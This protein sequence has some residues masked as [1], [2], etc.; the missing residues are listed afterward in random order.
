M[1]LVKG[2]IAAGV[3]IERTA[4]PSITEQRLDTK[5]QSI[6]GLEFYA[7]RIMKRHAD[8]GDEARGP[9][10][11][12]EQRRDAQA[13]TAALYRRMGRTT[14]ADEIERTLAA[15]RPPTTTKGKP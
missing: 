2:W 9:P 6:G 4:I 8:S 1:D 12:P 15:E 11:T 3:D 14:E 10:L 7:G 13:R 5:E